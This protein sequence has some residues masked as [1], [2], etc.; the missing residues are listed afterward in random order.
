MLFKSDIKLLLMFT[1]KS[2]WSKFP[3]E[4]N[5]KEEINSELSRR[6][7][8][9]QVESHKIEESTKMSTLKRQS[10]L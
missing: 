5:E 1:P 7:G 3:P 10:V 8:M 2:E 9:I 6:K 4:E